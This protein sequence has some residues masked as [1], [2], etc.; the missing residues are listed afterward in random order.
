MRR[1]LFEAALLV[2]AIAV[3]AAAF[4]ATAPRVTIYTHDLA[5]VQ[6]SRTL[7]LGGGRDTLRLPDVPDRIDFSS[8]RLDAGDR[9]KVERLAY[10]FD[11]ASGDG[12]L[13]HSLGRRVRVVSQQRE[14]VT[15]G[16]LVSADGSWLT[17]R[18]D[19]GGIVAV[20]RGDVGEVRLA[21]AAKGLSL[22]P[23]IEVVLQSDR[24]GDSPATLSYLTGGLSWGAEHRLVRTGE[25]TGRWSTTV[26]VD[27][28]SGR[29]YRD[30]SL[31]LVAGEPQRTGG[32]PPPRAMEMKT[33]AMAADAAPTMSE[34]T[35]GEYHL[36][37]LD[38]PA[39]LRDR[40]AQS[41]VMYGE[42]AVKITP[43]YL[44]RQGMPGV[45]SQIRLVNETANG[46]GVPVPA[47]R[48]RV[49]EPDGSGGDAFTGESSVGHTAAGEKLTI[50]VGTAFD[51]ATERRDI[52]NKRITD[53]ER[54]Y[55]VEIKLRDRKKT[56]V[57]IVVE[58]SVGGDFDVL[59]ETFKSTRKDANT[60]QWEIPVKAGAESVLRYT[61]RTRY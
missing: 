46:L 49:F 16:T 42:R 48:V 21:D 20:A 10:R 33:M 51:L 2:A 35:F 13:A 15:E 53:R 52:Y 61:V 17:L 25:T 47:G 54:E 41:L 39:L 22:K 14:R 7:T 8:V 26:T 50:D 28:T 29:E 58:E 36:Y 4:A 18:A 34:Q 31:R 60:L 44:V 9:A 57:V 37:T 19:D 59:D 12:L 43:R 5:W 56:D 38:K 40:E 24:K 45:L 32:M 27:N 55:Q 11:V 1:P 23:A 30:A 3:P 6:E